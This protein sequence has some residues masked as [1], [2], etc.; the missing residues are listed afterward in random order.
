M[1]KLRLFANLRELAGTSRLDVPSETVGGVIEAASEKFGPDFRRGV[2]TSRVWVNGEA[3]SMDDTVTEHDEVVLIPPVSG[4]DQ[5]T[6]TFSAVDLM[7]FLPAA[8]AVA[9]VLANTQGQDIWAAV[10]V[11]IVAIWAL[12]IGSAFEA[13]GREFASLA[14]VVT[15]AGS[16]M[17]AHVAGG[18]G[19]ALS[20]VIAVVVGL[21]WAVAFPQYRQVEVFSPT[22]MVALLAGL[23][24][25]SLV[26]ARSAHSPEASAV[27]VFLVS[28]IAAVGLSAILERINPIPLLDPFSVTALGAVLAAVAAALIWDLSVVS[29]LL[30]GLGI[31]VALLAGRGLSSML[32][33][34]RVVLTERPPG[35]LVSL[36]GVVLAAAIYYPL[37][38]LVL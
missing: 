24:T 29:Y 1:A 32:R 30:V 2:E 8:V 17:A 23:G 12:D 36:D 21:G 35:A 6:A 7:A 9:A 5:P 37:L 20:L 34:G 33:M 38:L 26:L 11:L 22:L 13:R 15:A 10:L 27:D 28:V 25:A 4:G 16:A 31:A 14:V 19:Y 18:G 3:A